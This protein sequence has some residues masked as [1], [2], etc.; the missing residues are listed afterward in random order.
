M[1]STFGEDWWRRQGLKVAD[2]RR[3]ANA[4]PERKRL[5]AMKRL[6]RARRRATWATQ[7]CSERVAFYPCAW[8]EQA[9]YWAGFCKKG[10]EETLLVP[11]GADLRPIHR[12]VLEI[13]M[14]SKP[15]ESADCEEGADGAADRRA[16]ESALKAAGVAVGPIAV[17]G[18]PGQ[19]VGG[20]ATSGVVVGAEAAAKEATEKGREKLAEREMRKSIRKSKR[21]AGGGGVTEV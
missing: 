13:M 7:D 4:A 12:E 19:G 5:R 21:A 3:K 14:K 17:E 11:E 16:H 2:A 15:P 18:L 8:S 20:D 1:R 9:L 6:R 10:P